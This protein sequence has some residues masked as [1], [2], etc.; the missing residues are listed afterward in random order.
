MVIEHNFDVIKTAHWVI[1]LGPEGGS[2]GSRVLATGTPEDIAHR[3]ESR[4]GRFL[5][6]LLGISRIWRWASGRTCRVRYALTPGFG[7]PR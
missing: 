2:G 1:D 4:T 3:P 7:R 5:K 6:S